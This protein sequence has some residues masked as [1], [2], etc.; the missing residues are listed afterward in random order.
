MTF[1]NYFHYLAQ[2]KE[3][4]IVK[5]KRTHEFCGVKFC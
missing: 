3:H 1:N 5:H 2:R 4:F